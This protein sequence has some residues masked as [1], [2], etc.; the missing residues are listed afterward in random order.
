MEKAGILMEPQFVERIRLLN[1][2]VPISQN[3]F[4]FTTAIEP[5]E[6]R[7]RHNSDQ[8]IFHKPR[9]EKNLIC[10]PLTRAVCFCFLYGKGNKGFLRF[11]NRTDTAILEVRML[12]MYIHYLPPFSAA[13]FRRLVFV[14]SKGLLNRNCK[15]IFFR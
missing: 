5:L 14:K 15:R 4:S 9:L 10:L 8:A 13:V 6:D 11:M 3:L 1:L 7:M 2:T 12:F